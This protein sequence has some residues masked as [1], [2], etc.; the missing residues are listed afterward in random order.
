MGSGMSIDLLY[1]ATLITAHSVIP[2]NAGI[3][4]G[5]GFRVKPGM[6]NRKGLMSLCIARTATLFSLAIRLVKY[7]AGGLAECV[8]WWGKKTPAPFSIPMIRIW[9]GKFRQV[10][11]RK[12]SP[13]ARKS[14]MRGSGLP[15][16]QVLR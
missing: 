10:K 16:L 2:A 1:T 5:T 3:Q 15:N 12:R 11:F 7:I 8:Y 6:T 4:E 14:L 13:V 9:E